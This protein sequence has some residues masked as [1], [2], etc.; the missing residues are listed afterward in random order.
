M[1]NLNNTDESQKTVYASNSMKCPEKAN[2]QRQKVGKLL[3]RVGIGMEN[4]CKQAGG[5][6]LGL[7]EFSKIRL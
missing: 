3:P 7:W 2:L 5:F 6:S 1:N 4:G